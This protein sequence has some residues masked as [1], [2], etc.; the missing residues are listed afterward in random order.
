MKQIFYAGFFLLCPFLLISCAG[1]RKARTTRT[2]TTARKNIEKENQQLTG[3]EKKLQS[4]VQEGNVDSSLWRALQ[5]KLEG[6][7]KDNE[8]ME[9]QVNDLETFMSH[10]E[11]FTKEYKRKI[12]SKTEL[13]HNRN[14]DF[15]HRTL[16]YGMIDQTLELAKPTVYGLSVFFGP[17]QYKVPELYKQQTAN[18]FGP[19]LDSIVNACNKY[20]KEKKDIYIAIRGYADEQAIQ[21]GTPLYKDLVAKFQLTAPDHQQLNLALSKLRADELSPVIQNLFQE[22][23]R[24]IRNIH[25]VNPNFYQEGC[26]ES[27]PNPKIKDYKM[28][29]ERRRIVVVFW[30]VLPSL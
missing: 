20:P 9:A 19:L 26:G 16:N 6:K 15:T 23:R 1:S 28:D 30:N 2:I 7:R 4:Q 18:A 27:L 17:G 13:L 10:P 8:K 25:N 3:L 24:R 21:P 12:K 22:Q 29:D 14:K 5:P 11:A